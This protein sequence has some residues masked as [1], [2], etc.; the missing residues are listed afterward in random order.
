[1]RLPLCTKPGEP[2][3]LDFSS[4]LLQRTMRIFARSPIMP[5]HCAYNLAVSHTHRFV[6]FRV[7]KVA[8]RSMLKALKDQ[9]VVLEAEHPMGVYYP[10]N[11][12]NEYFKFAF[13]RDPWDRF[14]S[15]W[16]NKIID[17]SL[18]AEDGVI[19]WEKLQDVHVSDL[20]IFENFVEYAESL[21]I[22]NCDLH[23]RLQCKLIDINNIDY[24][25][26]FESL[27]QDTSEVF[28]R[29]GLSP[30]ALP[31][32]NKSSTQ[33]HYS[34]YYNPQLR[35]R[36]ARIYEKDVRVFNYQFQDRNG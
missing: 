13:V 26:R 11:N 17:R 15:C 23:L 9:G 34:K 18:P 25:G 20:E 24:L 32:L 33:E 21:D 16:K 28:L 29:A 10:A 12:Y 2:Y 31:K 35:D 30:P 6:W 27:E 8:T 7:A 3:Q 19:R 5:S 14:V 4:R 22:E 36:V 1:M